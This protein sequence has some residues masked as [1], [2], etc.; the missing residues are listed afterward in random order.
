MNSILKKAFL[1]VVSLVCLGFIAALLPVLFGDSLNAGIT[2]DMASF[3]ESLGGVF[4][5]VF[6]VLVTLYGVLPFWLKKRFISMGEQLDEDLLGRILQ[7]LQMKL[8][9]FYLL[10]EIIFIQWL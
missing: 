1:L 5:R 8:V 3:G 9:V 10:I 2:D 4:P 6:V 7:S